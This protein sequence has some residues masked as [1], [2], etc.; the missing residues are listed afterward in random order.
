[1]K[2]LLNGRVALVTGSARGI[3]RAT[4]LAMAEAGA[5]VIVHYRRQRE[6]AE[7]V[8][9]EVEALGRRVL[10]V[11]ADLEEEDQVHQLF[12]AVQDAFGHLDIL[13]ANAAA[14]AFKPILALRAHHLERTYR[15]VVWSLIW[16]VQ[17]A[18]PLMEGRQGRIITLSGHGSRFTIPHYATIGSAKGAVESLTRYLAYELGPRRITCNAIAPGVVDTDSSR[19]YMGERFGA[20]RE[21]VSRHTPLGR[22]A[23][24]E[25]VAR[26]AVFL[27]SDLA[28][29]VTGQVITVDGGLTL[30]S[31][32]FEVEG[33]G[34]EPM[35]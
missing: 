24:P 34:P 18:A 11:Q 33:F 13:V 20:F 10:L 6:Q 17:R 15:L 7:A 9:R 4:A 3:G 26:V 23:T 22:I 5:D 27:A 21:A 35:R 30:T 31:G 12:N 16:A 8:A 14:T 29:F 28:G 25:D 32:P 19:Y 2:D 1:M